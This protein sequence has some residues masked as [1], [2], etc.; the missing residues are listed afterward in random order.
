MNRATVSSPDKA[1]VT[2]TL[3]RP[4][5]ATRRLRGRLGRLRLVWRRVAIAAGAGLL[6]AGLATA[7]L[8]APA[9]SDGGRRTAAAADDPVIGAALDGLTPAPTSAGQEAL[10]DDQR[11]LALDRSAIALP[12]SPGSVVEVIGLRP[13]VDDVRA[14]VI[15]ARAEVVGVTDQAILVLVDAGPAYT[16]AEIAAVGRVTILG[17]DQPPG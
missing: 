9:T 16:A 7:W 15:T 4:T 5:T 11:I 3:V 12:V 2:A 14:E 1:A 13:T 17:R 10:A 8:T 6:A